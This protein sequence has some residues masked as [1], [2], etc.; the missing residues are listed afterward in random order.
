MK[1]TKILEVIVSDRFWAWV[2]LGMTFYLYYFPDEHVRA[3][4][5]F[6][7]SAISLLSYD[8]NNKEDSNEAL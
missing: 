8:V 2:F 1:L 3:I 5:A 7:L 6:I 4:D